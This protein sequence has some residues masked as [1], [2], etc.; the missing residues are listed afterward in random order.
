MLSKSSS[1]LDSTLQPD[2][3]TTVLLAE[4]VLSLNCFSFAEE[5]YQHVWGVAMGMR[6]A[7]NYA[8]LLVGYVHM[9][10]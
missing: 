8:N 7:P 2:I 4:L 1:T 5:F 6:M 9:I 10:H 3:S